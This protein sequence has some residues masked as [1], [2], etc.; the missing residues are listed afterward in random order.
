MSD[1]P[2][3]DILV[4]LVVEDALAKETELDRVMMLLV[5]KIEVPSDWPGP[6]PYTFVDVGRYIGLRF[7]GVPLSEATVR[8]RRDLIHKRWRI[9]LRGLQHD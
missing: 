5:H 7:R 4:R 9:S 1:D 6:W 2:E 3:D 8:Y